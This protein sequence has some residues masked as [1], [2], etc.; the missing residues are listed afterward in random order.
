MTVLVVKMMVLRMVIQILACYSAC[1]KFYNFY[2]Y[3]VNLHNDKHVH[4]SAIDDHLKSAIKFSV[5][6]DFNSELWLYTMYNKLH[7]SC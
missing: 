5:L 3:A 6:I 4:M 2:F 1:Y 7:I